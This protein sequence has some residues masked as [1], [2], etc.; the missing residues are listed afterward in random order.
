MSRYALWRSADRFVNHL[1]SCYHP[2]C[3]VPLLEVQV[4]T[5]IY[6]VTL[7]RLHLFDLDNHGYS[8]RPFI[9]RNRASEPYD[10]SIDTRPP[11]CPNLRNTYGAFFSQSLQV[12]NERPV[13]EKL[14]AFSRVSERVCLCLW[15]KLAPN[16]YIVLRGLVMYACATG[17]YWTRRVSPL[18]CYARIASIYDH[19]SLVVRSFTSRCEC[20]RHVSHA[21]QQILFLQIYLTGIQGGCVIFKNGVFWGKTNTF[22]DSWSLQQLSPSAMQCLAFG[23]YPRRFT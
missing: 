12:C 9:A 22:S 20:F 13:P 14:F 7:Y 1:W 15:G 19:H 2:P 8:L 16:T 23:P 4:S 10:E 3:L 21:A 17:K 5:N 18:S 6:C 11:L